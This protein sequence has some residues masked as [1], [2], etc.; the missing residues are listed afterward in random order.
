MMANDDG[1]GYSQYD[2]IR[3]DGRGIEPA[4]SSI[5]PNVGLVGS[6]LHS[7]ALIPKRDVKNDRGK[8]LER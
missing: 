8:K 1:A 3:W 7:R 6:P 4:I 2:E 5:W